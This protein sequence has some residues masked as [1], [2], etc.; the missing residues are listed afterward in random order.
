MIARN[1]GVFGENAILPKTKRIYTAITKSEE[2]E[3]YVIPKVN[4][5]E[6]MDHHQGIQAK[7]MTAFAQQYDQY[8]SRLFE[9]YKGS[10]G[11]FDLNTVY[12]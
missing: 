6:I 3:L 7:I 5:L 8:T 9:T 4:I 10:R 11:F 2:S 12:S 1:G